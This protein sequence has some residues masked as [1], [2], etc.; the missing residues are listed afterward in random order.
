[1]R[2]PLLG[3]RDRDQGEGEQLVSAWRIAV[4][5]AVIAALLV[6]RMRPFSDWW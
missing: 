3:S 2:N 4:G 6:W 5:V 1:M